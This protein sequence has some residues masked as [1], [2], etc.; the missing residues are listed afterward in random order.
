MVSTNNERFNRLAKNIYFELPEG[1]YDVK[2]Y[3]YFISLY[4]DSISL[5]SSLPNTVISYKINGIHSSDYNNFLFCPPLAILE[6]EEFRDV[7]SYLVECEVIMGRH[8]FYVQESKSTF[9]HVRFVIESIDGDIL[10]QYQM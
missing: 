4:E 10:A 5:D 8:G 6:S 3:V 7:F 2:D 9:I 1:N